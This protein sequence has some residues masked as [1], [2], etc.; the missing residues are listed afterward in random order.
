MGWELG[1]FTR[2]GTILR[3][4]PALWWASKDLFNPG[5][6]VRDGV[7][8][9]LVRGEDDTPRFAGTSRIGLATSTDGLSFEVDPEPVLGP[10]DDE[11]ADWE[12]GGGCEDPRV[13]ESPEGGYVCLYTG[14]DGRR[15]T[16][17]AAISEDLRTWTKRG[18]AFAGTPY[19][20]RSSKSGAVVTEVRDGRLVA[21]RIGGAFWMYW[22]EGTCFAA[23]SE[24]LLRWIPV[25]FD[26]TADHHLE[27][28]DGGWTVQRQPGQRALRPLVSP[29]TGRFD[30]RLVE[31]GPPAVRTA[32]GIVLLCNGADQDRTYQTGQIL[33]DPADPTAAI[34]RTT[35][36]FLQPETDDERSGQVPNVSF[37]E[38]LVLLDGTWHL[39]FGMADSRIG[40]ATAPRE[41][42]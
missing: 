16:L 10:G 7:V 15:G 26:A 11:W 19:A 31:P 12:R 4:S 3:S 40:C 28:L 9:L 25:D 14:F 41:G 1:P 2:R 36:P 18:P 37:A 21:A 30:S 5:A 29:R 38:G 35:A 8:H 24:D 17:M 20:T 32:D 22:G 27:W 34:A 39:Y 13:V 23:T 6:A 42:P 33:F